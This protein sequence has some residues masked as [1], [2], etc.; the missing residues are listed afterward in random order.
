MFKSKIEQI[1]ILNASRNPAGAIFKSNMTTGSPINLNTV[2]WPS[3]ID[4]TKKR[5]TAT[6]ARE[7]NN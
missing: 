6:D 1:K 2:Q 5:M 7:S 3:T 4:K